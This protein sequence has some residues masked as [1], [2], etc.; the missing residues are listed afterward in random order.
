MVTWCHFNVTISRVFH[1][2]IKSCRMLTRSGNGLLIWD[3]CNFC[4]LLKTL[5]LCWLCHC[6]WFLFKLGLCLTQST[7]CRADSLRSTHSQGGCTHHRSNFEQTRCPSLTAPVYC[8]RAIVKELEGRT[9]CGWIWFYLD[10][11]RHLC[12]K[13]QLGAVLLKWDHGQSKPF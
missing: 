13:E 11:L 12:V 3:S 8:D 7:D 1:S 9:G 4:V 10:V 2:E 5:A 6:F